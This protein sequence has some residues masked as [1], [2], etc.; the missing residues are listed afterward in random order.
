MDQALKH[1]QQDPIL[2]RLIAVIPPFEHRRTGD[3]FPDLVDSIV[4]QQ[5]SMKAA[6]TIFG[7]F[8]ALFPKEI[9]TPEA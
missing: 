5:L 6:A 7:R 9:I 3:I 4:S 8:K 2:K 1:L